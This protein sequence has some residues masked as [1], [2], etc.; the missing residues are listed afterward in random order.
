MVVAMKTMVKKLKGEPRA[1]QDGMGGALPRASIFN[2]RRWVLNREAMA[3][4]DDEED[5]KRKLVP[6]IH[7]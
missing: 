3:Q 6:C 4:N 1:D 5:S 7:V 2:Y